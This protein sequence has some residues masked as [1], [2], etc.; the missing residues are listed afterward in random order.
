MDL[1]TV[2]VSSDPLMHFDLRGNEPRPELW[3]PQ[4]FVGIWNPDFVDSS[5]IV[6]PP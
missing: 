4:K 3:T 1:T 6:V 2:V 5:L